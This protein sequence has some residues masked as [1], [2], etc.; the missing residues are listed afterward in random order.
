MAFPKGGHLSSEVR[1][2]LSILAKLRLADKF[3]HPFYGKKLS[4]STKSKISETKKC[5]YAN[6]LYEP[7]NKGKSGT[8]H[9]WQNRVHP[10]CGKPAWNSGHA[11]LH[12]LKK[13]CE[14]CGRE[15]VTP[16]HFRMRR[17]CSP[18][19]RSKLPAWNKGLTLADSRVQKN[20]NARKGFRH[21]AETKHRMSVHRKLLW[22][23]D[24]FREKMIKIVI[25]N[26]Q[27][28]PTSI[29]RLF[30]SFIEKYGLPFKY[31]G[32]GSFLI[33][34][35]CPDFIDTIN[36]RVCIEVRHVNISERFYDSGWEMRRFNYFLEHGWTCFFFYADNKGFFDSESIML[37]KICNIVNLPF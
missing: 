6:G 27:K 4:E 9:L 37:R 10:A 28:R 33:G 5:N 26:T 30:I 13:F 22:S 3:N 24:E 8:Y 7:W 35:R 2:R 21:S 11:K 23:D 19:C 17:T 16:F 14:I 20:A 36:H 12:E 18:E 32:N 1:E 25:A 15:F 31:V 34:D 29:E